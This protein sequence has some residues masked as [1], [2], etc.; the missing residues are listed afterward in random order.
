MERSAE[1]LLGVIEDKF[2]LLQTEEDSIIKERYYKQLARWVLLYYRHNDPSHG[3]PGWDRQ[4]RTLT[5]KARS[6]FGKCW[7]SFWSQNMGHSIKKWKQ[8]GRNT[9]YAYSFGILP[10]TLWLEQEDSKKRKQELSSGQYLQPGGQDPSAS[11]STL[12]RQ[13]ASTCS[14]T[15]ESHTGILFPSQEQWAH[16]DLCMFY[17]ILINVSI[18]SDAQQQQ[19]FLSRPIWSQEDYQ[20]FC[21]DSEHQSQGLAIPP[22]SMTGQSVTLW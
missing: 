20:R 5:T 6:H 3:H 16:V 17:S 10:R 21:A 9:K 7:T 22:N 1:Q 8:S 2:K 12:I 11:S 4:S 13:L 18:R 14:L 15:S 19:L